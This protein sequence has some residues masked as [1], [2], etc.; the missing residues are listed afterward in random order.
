MF[1]QTVYTPGAAHLSYI[2]GDGGEAAVIDPRRD[3]DVYLRI[4]RREG[5]KITHVF[6]THIA[7]RTTR[8][9]RWS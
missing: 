6:E 9:A 3:V 4:A 1:M 5:A 8:S 7:T 2:L